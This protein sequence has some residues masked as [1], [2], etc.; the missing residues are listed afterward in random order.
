MTSCSSWFHGLVLH[1]GEEN[2]LILITKLAKVGEE[3]LSK[4]TLSK[5]PQIF[6]ICLFC[7]TSLVS[8]VIVLPNTAPVWS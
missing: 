7:L 8:C 6:L 2:L 5:L 4:N 1:F 3:E